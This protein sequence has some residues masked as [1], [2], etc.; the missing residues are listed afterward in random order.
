MRGGPRDYVVVH[1]PDKSYRSIDP[2]PMSRIEAEQYASGAHN[3]QAMH[4]DDAMRMFGDDADA[5]WDLLKI[6]STLR[7]GDVV[8][9]GKFRAK[10]QAA[11]AAVQRTKAPPADDD[12][13]DGITIQ[14]LFDELIDSSD[15]QHSFDKQD[16]VNMESVWSNGS[17]TV[18]IQVPKVIFIRMNM[19]VPARD[20]IV[21]FND[22]KEMDGEEFYSTLT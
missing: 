19:R 7:E 3:V 13:S 14:T 8:D 16:R 21:K 1:N 18:T 15:W 20:A 10:K 12:E 17:E 11:Q 2:M 9:L 5:S 22:G 4:I 6:K